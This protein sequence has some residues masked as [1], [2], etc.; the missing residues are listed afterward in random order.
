MHRLR[1][2]IVPTTYKGPLRLHDFKRF[3]SKSA[4]SAVSAGVVQN[5]AKEQRPDVVYS[6]REIFL[7]GPKDLRVPL[8]GN[9]GIV[10][11]DFGK[12]SETPVI[13]KACDVLTR[14][15]KDERHHNILAQF[16]HPPEELIDEAFPS[17]PNPPSVLECAAQDCP[18]LLKKDFQDLFPS[19]NIEND[20]LTVITLTH[21]T[22]NDMNYWSEDGDIER[23]QLNAQF[24]V[25]ARMICST[26]QDSGYWADFIDPTSG[27][28][29]LG[30]Y[31]SSTMLET[32]ERY[33]NFGFTIEDLGCCK[34]ITHHLWGSN[35]L[36]G[37]LFTNAPF[38]SPE[39]RKIICEHNA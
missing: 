32:D 6:E 38:D 35:A 5:D 33:K 16:L 26:L 15:T 29:Y 34:V 12:D 11:L 2:A 9:V 27:R 28:P 39:V 8:P 22:E 23:D 13:F 18:D 36:V 31:T 10:P 17:V 3:C 19:Q 14:E 25:K 24:V 21:K 7:F 1:R 37:C 4:P 30:P 20:A